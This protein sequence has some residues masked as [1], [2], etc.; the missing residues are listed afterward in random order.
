VKFWEHWRDSGQIAEHDND[1][2]EKW[3]PPV[4]RSQ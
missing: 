4:F 2:N 1:D 3:L